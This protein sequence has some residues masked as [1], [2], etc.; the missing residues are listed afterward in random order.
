LM[1]GGQI[2]NSLVLLG[3]DLQDESLALPLHL[4]PQ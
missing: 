3:L 2:F 1:L 4:F